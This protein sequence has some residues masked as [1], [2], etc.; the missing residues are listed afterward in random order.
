MRIIIILITCMLITV[1]V[2]SSTILWNALAIVNSLAQVINSIGLVI[3]TFMINSLGI[4]FIIII[5]YRD[6]LKNEG[7]NIKR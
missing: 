2:T 7:S 6:Y 4:T 5:V 3:V 1:N